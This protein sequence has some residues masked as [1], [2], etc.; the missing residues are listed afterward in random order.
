MAITNFTFEFDLS[1]VFEKLDKDSAEEKRANIKQ[2]RERNML[3]PDTC[4]MPFNNIN[5]LLELDC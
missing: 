3:F 5:D 2:L 4:E 1:S